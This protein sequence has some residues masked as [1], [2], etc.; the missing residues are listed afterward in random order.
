MRL[1]EGYGLDAG[2][3]EA[4]AAPDVFAADEVVAADHVALCLGETGAVALVGTAP[5]L[6]FLAA[7]EPGDLVL[8]L[9][10]AMGAGH[11]VIAGFG[12]FVEKVFLFH[13]IPR[14]A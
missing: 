4:F 8:A 2:D 6:G 13:G 5:E 14:G 7:D 3:V 10:A 1:D 12:A 11:G 9:L